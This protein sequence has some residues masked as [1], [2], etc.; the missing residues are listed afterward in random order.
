MPSEFS[1]NDDSESPLFRLLDEATLENDNN[2]TTWE[3][4]TTPTSAPTSAP[5]S[6]ELV[7][8]TDSE[9]IRETFR[10]YGSLYLFFFVIFCVARKYFPKLY[11]I[12]SWVPEMEC[13]LAKNQQYGFV[14]WCWQVFQISDDELLENCGMDALCFLRCLRLGSHLSLLGIFCSLFLI[15]MYLTAEES[16]ETAY[17][18]DIFVKMSIANLP[19][20]SKRFIGVV[21]AMYII[22]LY[23]MVLITKEY[24]W[25]IEY[26]HKYLSQ[27]KPRNYGCYVSGIL[28]DYRSSH[29]LADYFKQCSANSA[30]LEAHIAIDTPSLDKMVARREVVVRKL[31]HVLALEQKKGKRKTHITFQIQNG[32]EGV[33]KVDSIDA[34]TSELDEL[35]KKIAMEIGEI[36][37]SNHPLRKHLVKNQ[38]SSDVVQQIKLSPIANDYDNVEGNIMKGGANETNGAIDL[39]TSAKTLSTIG[40]QDQTMQDTP[41]QPNLQNQS[42]FSDNFKILPEGDSKESTFCETKARTG[43]RLQPLEEQEISLENLRT[44]PETTDITNEKAIMKDTLSNDGSQLSATELSS[45]STTPQHSDI[46]QHPFWSM[47][48]LDASFFSPQ[49]A[50]EG[51]TRLHRSV[52]DP[53]LSTSMARSVDDEGSF[54]IGGETGSQ[55][56]LDTR[57]LTTDSAHSG[58]KQDSLTDIE[59]GQ[60]SNIPNLKGRSSVD[61]SSL[62]STSNIDAYRSQSWSSG[63]RNVGNIPHSVRRVGEL[64]AQGVKT[65][66][67][68]TMVVGSRVRSAIKE[69]NRDNVSASIKKAGTVG[70]QGIKTAGSIG[71]A[72][73]KKA[74]QTIQ[75]APDLGA[76]IATTAAESAAGL[77]PVLLQKTDGVPRTAGFVVFCDLYST[78]AARQMLHHPSGTYVSF[79]ASCFDL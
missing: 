54:A 25:F 67:A 48:G 16:E 12:R 35:N 51:A 34:Y 43:I 1:L 57:Q 64:G 3:P 75:Q 39:T 60:T 77:V 49:S 56:D 58:I 37:N 66:S 52:S 17:L 13:D 72:S 19:N 24:D 53:E 7:T 32:V 18:T 50:E 10:L 5:T 8:S 38:G 69:V 40:T 44:I 47:L 28:P 59:Q 78:Q 30:V 26:R 9:I 20:L 22:V 62:M 73:V 2:V 21:V 6:M 23:G 45:I 29:A 27:P 36:R 71:V 15:P 14:A 33:K 11:N 76:T 46:P 79:L 55:E 63:R 41:Q 61:D 65:V 31:E 68:G 42:T 4:T 74:A 70:A